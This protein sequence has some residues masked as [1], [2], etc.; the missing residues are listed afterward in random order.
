MAAAV[1]GLTDRKAVLELN[2][3]ALTVE[4]SPE[5]QHVYQEGPAEFV[6]DGTVEN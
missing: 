6:F 4:W 1:N 5:D 2:G 3:G